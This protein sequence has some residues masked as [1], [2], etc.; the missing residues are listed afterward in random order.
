MHSS[1]QSWHASR[2]AMGRQVCWSTIASPIRATRFSSMR[3]RADRAGGADLAAGV[4]ARLAAGPVGVD[5]GGPEPLEALLEAH[6]AGARCWGRPGSTRR[7]GCTSA[8]T[9]ARGRCRAG[10][11][12]EGVRVV[13][14]RRERFAPTP[15][16]IPPGRSP[17]RPTAAARKPRRP[18]GVS[19]RRRIVH[20]FSSTRSQRVDELDRVRGA[21][22][23]AGLAERAVGRARGEVGL[24]RVERADLDALVAVDA[25]RLDLP[26]GRAE[27]VA[28]REDRAARADVLA[29][30]PAAEER[31]ARAPPAN[32][33]I[34]T[35]WP[36]F[37][38]GTW[39]QPRG[40]RP[41]GAARR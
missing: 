34:E 36:A 16:P 39:C 30:E 35:K 7:S 24:D 26:L 25:A 21:D 6:A 12:G 20:I 40:Q 23:A 17:R 13:E 27:E 5:V 1:T 32:R 33:A 31:R 3:K 8:G 10:G 11:P 14:V 19:S 29:P 15:P 28:Q 18:S 41:S 38:A 2:P 4:A 9:P 37:T 22:A